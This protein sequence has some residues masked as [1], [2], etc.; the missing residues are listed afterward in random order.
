MSAQELKCNERIDAQLSSLEES[1]DDLLKNYYSG[2]EGGFDEWN[3][4]PL[5]VTTRKETRI[6]LSWGGPSDFLSVIHDGVDI[7]TI[8]YHFL[9]WFDGAARPV[10]QGSKVWEYAQTV[11]EMREECS[12]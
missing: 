9:D 7:L 10:Y 11:I 6:E 3:E 5:A 2:E 12:L 1:C 4:F 8:T